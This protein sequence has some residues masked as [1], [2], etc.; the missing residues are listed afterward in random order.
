MKKIFTLICALTAV[1]ATA[2]AQ[3]VVFTYGGEVLEEGAEVT[4]QAADWTE[5]G[6]GYLADSN[7]PKSLKL[8]NTGATS[9]N[10]T[11]NVKVIAGDYSR[12][13]WC[14]FPAQCRKL[15]SESVNGSGSIGAGT[16]TPLNLDTE[17][18]EGEYGVRSVLVTATANGESV[19]MTFHMENKA[20]ESGNTKTYTDD[21]VV[22]INGMSTP[23]QQSDIKV[24]MA[25]DGTSMDL[26]LNNFSLSLEGNVMAVGNILLEDVQF[27][28]SDNYKVFRTTQTINITAGDDP[29]QTWLGPMLGD[30]P[31]VMV[32]KINDGKLFCTINIDM[33]ESL[34]QIIHVS[35]GSDLIGGNEYSDNMSVSVEGEEIGTFPGVAYAEMFNDGTMFLTLKDLLFDAGDGDVLPFGNVML[36]NVKYE[37]AGSI[38]NFS[39]E[40]T[41]MIVNGTDTTQEWLSTQLGFVPVKVSGKLDN[42]NLYCTF[43]FDMT[44]T[45]LG[46]NMIVVFGDNDKVTSISSLPVISSE[47]DIYR[48]D[49]TLVGK[50]ANGSFGNLPKGVYI[51]NGKKIIK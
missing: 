34:Q 18:H 33:M 38:T 37:T 27:I 2:Q 19:S 46:V 14:S 43:E 21:L 30:V 35:F 7:T 40:E 9:V 49:G 25:E 44:S 42:G 5:F 10:V 31:I 45:P 51:V 13:Q 39:S 11:V 17:F 50:V 47:V 3:D 36:T 29:D 16:E 24:V 8:K 28:E 4:V 32:G 1:F 12:I 20:P 26:S 6:M 41:I 23:A 15:A 22:T 48:L